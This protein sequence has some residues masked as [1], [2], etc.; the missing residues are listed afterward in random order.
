MFLPFSIP[1]PYFPTVCSVHITN[2]NDIQ[3]TSLIAKNTCKSK[4]RYNGRENNLHLLKSFS[5]II[6]HRYLL[7]ILI[8]LKA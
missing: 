1:T 4:L 7:A 6:P 3:I 8:F 2:R 5:F